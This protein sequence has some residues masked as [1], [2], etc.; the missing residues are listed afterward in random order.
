MKKL[1][2]LL[3]A[4]T[5]ICAYAQ[6]IPKPDAY[7]K[8]ITTE[9]LKKHLYIIA[10]PEMEGRET[11]TEGQRK[12]AAYIENY[13]KTVGLQPVIGDSYQMY[14][15][16]YQD[17]LVTASLEVNG[18]VFEFDKDFG[19]GNTTI[20]ATMKLGEVVVLGTGATDSLKN[21]DLVGKLVMVVGS[22]N[23]AFFSQL[24]KKG[25]RLF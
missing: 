1:L 20:Q 9:D 3:L 14:Y 8:T 6:K 5:T 2:T 23:Q 10:S 17:S 13:F 7:A 22:V 24:S 21:A 19:I 4:G 12:A 18:K 11:G 16:L 15:N 25:R